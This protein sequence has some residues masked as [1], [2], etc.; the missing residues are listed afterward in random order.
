MNE[1]SRE[2]KIGLFGVLVAILGIAVGVL[3]IEIRRYLGLKSEIAYAQK[4]L[5]LADVEIKPEPTPKITTAPPRY[6]ERIEIIDPLTVRRIKFARGGT[7]S[8]VKGTINYA[9]EHDFLLEARGEQFMT[10]SLSS[11]SAVFLVYAP[12]GSS[13]LET[14]QAEWSG[15]LPLSGDYRVKVFANGHNDEYTLKVS[16]R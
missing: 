9:S 14:G 11:N 16:I 12:N 7:S 6:P 5:P 8:I 1:W 13:L 15:V 3:T 4:P 10:V 2:A